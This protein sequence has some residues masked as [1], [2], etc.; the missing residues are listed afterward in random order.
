MAERKDAGKVIM[1]LLNSFVTYD[2]LTATLK[3]WISLVKA[4][5]YL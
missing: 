5:A 4:I 3:I 2:D 1:L